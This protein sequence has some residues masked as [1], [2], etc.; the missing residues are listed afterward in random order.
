MAAGPDQRLCVSIAMEMGILENH[1]RFD[2]SRLRGMRA[3][4]VFDKPI[5]KAA[6]HGYVDQ[7]LVTELGCGDIVVMDNLS[8]HKGA[9]LR[10]VIEAAE[11]QQ[12]FK[13][14]RHQT[15]VRMS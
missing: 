3:P 2:Y 15:S 8:K 10:A 12:Q 1:L 14:K 7:V 6:F 9:D 11:T 5:N 13:N 4:D